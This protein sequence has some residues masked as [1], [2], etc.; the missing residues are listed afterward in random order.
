MPK[1]L[2]GAPQVTFKK[3]NGSKFT[4]TYH[5]RTAAAKSVKAWRSS[6]GRV[7]KTGTYKSS[8][9]RSKSGMTTTSGRATRDYKNYKQSF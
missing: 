3:R 7:V 2:G 9:N 5:S 4:M 6:G 8:F 1:F